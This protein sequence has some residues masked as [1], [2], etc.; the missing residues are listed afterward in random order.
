MKAKN[1]VII[2]FVLTSIIFA[3]KT[4][5]VILISFD[6]FRWD[7]CERGIT[8][9]LDK[10]QNEGVRAKSLKPVFPS[11]TFPNHYSIISGMYPED[12]GIIANYFTNPFTH[13]RYRVGDTVSVRQGKWYQGEAIWETARRN[14]IV[15]ASYFWPGSEIELEYRRPNYFKYY[16]HN[17]T[18]K[19]RIDGV[20]NWLNLPQKER[21]HFITLYFH[22][23]D[24][25]G[26]DF[27][28]NSI[29]INQ[30]IK[31]LDS[32]LG[33]LNSEI[34]KL[35]TKDSIDIILVSDHGMTEVCKDKIINVDEI[36]SDYKFR[37]DSGET[38]ALIEPEENKLNEVYE[39]LKKN[40]N[41]FK[42]YLKNEM[43]EYYHF[44]NH[45]FITTIILIADL[46]WTVVNNKLLKSYTKSNTKGNH[47]YDN[48]ELD[49]HG[50]FFA[51]GPHFK[52]NY[53]IGTLLN[54]DIYPLLAKIFKINPRNN[55]DGKLERIEFILK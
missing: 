1:V 52:E 3:Q 33:Y 39:I 6:G 5:Y 34:N 11:K 38:F 36:L 48:N 16:E 35:E 46:G 25:Y 55:I 45:Q 19:E 2:F 40:E 27:G 50:I 13:E 21:P 54:V 47:G 32:L 43:P 10:L 37:F 22:D 7:Y 18:Y 41:H 23:T 9:N 26:H 53:K 4:P 14:G 12:H 31:R 30:S 49:M 51:K 15:T 42:V 17:K 20:I 8:P 24:S 28:P 29:E 44:S